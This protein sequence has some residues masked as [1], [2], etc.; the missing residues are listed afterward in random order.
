MPKA[1]YR[2][3]LGA[4]LILLGVALAVGTMLPTR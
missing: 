3:V 1:T 2:V 4:L